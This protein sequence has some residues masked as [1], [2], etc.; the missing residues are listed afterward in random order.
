MP[1]KVYK[2]WFHTTNPLLSAGVDAL[3]EHGRWISGF[4][5]DRPMRVEDVGGKALVTWDPIESPFPHPWRVTWNDDG[6]VNVQGG[7]VYDGTQAV[8][9]TGLSAVALAAEDKVWL[10]VHYHNDPADP[11]VVEL[12][13]GADWPDDDYDV[14]VLPDASPLTLP[15]AGWSTTILRVAEI[16]ADG[17]LWQ[18]L[19]EDARVPKGATYTETTPI[20]YRVSGTMIQAIMM[21][22]TFVNGVPRPLAAAPVAVDLFDTG[23]CPS[24]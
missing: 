19:W 20:G 18:Y 4:D 21:T 5:A 14:D 6:T 7:V 9:V 2:H 16:D 1:S 11:D 8:A 13:Y 23:V 3:N 15:K 24:T 12:D 10:S 22:K 17:V